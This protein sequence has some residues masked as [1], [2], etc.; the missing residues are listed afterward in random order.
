MAKLEARMTE[1]A[2]RA[3]AYWQRLERRARH[4]Y[5]R[6]MVVAVIVAALLVVAWLA[7]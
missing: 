7:Q 3:E 2:E 4:A 1:V 6:Q 5:V